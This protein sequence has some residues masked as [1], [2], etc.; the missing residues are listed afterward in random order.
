MP[1]IMNFFPLTVYQDDVPEH[2]ALKD[3]LID[4]VHKRA[5]D[6]PDEG[7]DYAWTGDMHGHGFLHLE[8]AFEPL[9]EAFVPHIRKYLEVFDLRTDNLSLYFQRSW[10]VVTR[11][12]QHVAP[13]SHAQSHISL[14]YYLKKPDKSGG[15]RFG[16]DSAPNELAPRL[17]GVRM[18]GFRTKG[19]PLNSNLIDVDTEEGQILL[20]PS[21]ATHGTNLNESDE[22]RIS[23]S[24]DI[25]MTLKE[26]S[27]FENLMPA[28]SKWKQCL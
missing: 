5:T 19:T 18:E 24:A 2:G 28:L 7:H 4:E 17:F 23:I 10:P 25:I 13:H 26:D 3:R 21:K 27:N 22:E 12:T 6:L 14:V 1:Y 9:F 8:P 11:R 15:L 20:F 16:V